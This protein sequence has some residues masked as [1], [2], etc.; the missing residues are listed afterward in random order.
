MGEVKWIKITTNMFDDEKIKLIDAMPERDTIFYIWIRLLVQAGK[1]NAG[2]YIFLNENIPYTEEMLSTIYNRQLN[3]VRLAL[4]TL[5]NFGMIKIT[6]D[7]LIKLTNWEKYQNIE[8]MEKVREQ[9][10]NRVA[11]H[12]EKQKQLPEAGKEDSATDNKNNVTVTL[13]NGTEG[14]VEGEGDIE[15]DR[16]TTPTPPEENV[17]SNYLDFF[18]NNFHPITAF[19]LNILK[20]Y[21]DDGME[22][23]VITIALQQAIEANA[24][25]IRYVKKIIS[26]WLDNNIKTV[27]AVKADRAEWERKNSEKDNKPYQENKKV[28]IYKNHKQKQ[29]DIKAI[30]KKL[31][32][33]DEE[34]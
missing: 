12:R 17:N 16:D 20:S 34:E 1:T 19:E 2:G 11:K 33:W 31:L 15:V 10:R 29:Y 6:E 5:S 32:G 3:T 8:G 13:P 18:T 4:K 26:R 7:H 24:K 21:Q 27:E 25:D 28:S 9:T 14:E 22:P 30:E 23:A